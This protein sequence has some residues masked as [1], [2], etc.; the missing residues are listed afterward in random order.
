M[1]TALKYYFKYVPKYYF[2]SLLIQTVV[3][4]LLSLGDSVLVPSIVAAYFAETVE[5]NV[6]IIAILS[7]LFVNIAYA[8]IIKIIEHRTVPKLNRDFSKG[9]NM[10]L[11]TKMNSISLHYYDNPDFYDKYNL[12]K[13][14]TLPSIYASAGLILNTVSQ[15]VSIGTML[16]LI[17]LIDP[18]ILLFMIA[19]AVI[20]VVIQI[21]ISVVSLKMQ[22]ESVGIKHIFE[23]VSRTFYLKRYALDQRYTDIADVNLCLYRSTIGKVDSLIKKMLKRVMPL[24]CLDASVTD[25]LIYFSILIFSCYRITVLNQYPQVNWSPSLQARLRCS[26]T[27]PESAAF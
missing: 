23:Y 6:V 15:I 18:V 13:Q 10:L 25:V 7:L 3:V 21:M 16:T 17:A 14:N 5:I 9:I 12:A 26:D 11:F 2:I 8:C 22:K 4:A 20:S 27:C 19:C 24:D 1:K